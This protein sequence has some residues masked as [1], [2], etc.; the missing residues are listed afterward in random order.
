[1]CSEVLSP[2]RNDSARRNVVRGQID[3]LLLTGR[4]NSLRA[5]CFEISSIKALIPFNILFTLADLW[6]L[7]SRLPFYNLKMLKL[8]VDDEVRVLVIDINLQRVRL[9]G[10]QL[11]LDTRG[12]VKS[13]LLS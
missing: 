6:I 2:Y 5:H 7:H 11:D 8:A 12:R 10:G 9:I 1:M 13:H 3:F 4:L